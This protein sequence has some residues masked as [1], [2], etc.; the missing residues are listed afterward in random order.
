MSHEFLAVL[1]YM[2]KD[3]G[4]D[5]KVMIKA[6][7]QALISAA[8]RNFGLTRD[9]RVQLDAKSGRLQAY[10]S[11][12]AV[13]K[14]AKPYEEILLIKARAKKPLANLGDLV[15]VEI[16]PAE[17]GRIAAQ[18]FKQTL[19]QNVRSIE[20][21]MIFDEFK[22]RVGDLVAGTVRRFERSDV[23]VDLGKF[24]AIMP[25]KERVPTEEYSQGER[26]RALI[27]SVDNTARGP[28]IILTR[29]H[30]SFVRR[31]FELEVNELHDGT[32]EIK[33]LAREAGYRTKIAVW[34]E[35]E[36]IDP[37]GACV[38][39]RGARVKNIVRELNNEKI[40]LFRWSGNIRELI[41]EA[42]KPAKLKHLDLDQEAKRATATVDEE[43]LSLAIGRRGQ[44]ARLTAKLTGWEI[45]ITREEHLEQTFE[46]KFANAAQRLMK[47]LA[48]DNETATLLVKSGFPNT[49]VL[50]QTAPADIQ[51]A[52]PSLSADVI[53]SILKK[54]GDSKGKA[55][56]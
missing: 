1:E 50:E 54:V 53:E 25:A 19:N 31:L 24:E 43:N 18:V 49:E 35:D 46:D 2:E 10:A 15:E 9:I 38:G 44:N 17:L 21:T 34:S 52:I 28:Q 51:E 13:E 16:P 8:R 22:D 48:I 26:I 32:V 37:V 12:K 27:L 30:P 4:I 7:E 55:T 36:K 3:K 33:A 14:V 40:D 11:M 42:L 5:R 41:I 29:S 20:K 56:A 6:I 47:Q 45:D 39:L 23:I